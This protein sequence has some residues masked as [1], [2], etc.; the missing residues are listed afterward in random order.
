M[1]T[2]TNQRTSRQTAPSLQLNKSLVPIDQYAAR[3]GL[4]TSIVEECG[5]LGIVQLRTYKGKTFVVNAPISPCLCPS[6]ADK[7]PTRP[8]DKNTRAQKISELMQR[9]VSEKSISQ[10][11]PKIASPEEPAESKDETVTVGAIS[12]LVKKMFNNAPKITAK[13]VQT[14]DDKTSR[15]QDTKKPVAAPN[16]TTQTRPLP[17]VQPPDMEIFEL[18]DEPPAAVH[19]TQE[20]REPVQ[21]PQNNGLQ[22]G[23]L[24]AQGRSKRIWQTTAVLSLGFLFM[25]VVANISLFVNRRTQL[26]R[27]DEANTSIQSLFDG[28]AQSDQQVENLRNEM[29][30]SKA[31]AG[32]LQSE[33]YISKDEL[34]TARNELTQARQDMENLRNELGKSRAEAGRFQAKLGSYETEISRL[35]IELDKSRAELKTAQDNFA[36]ATQELRTIRQRNAEAADRLNK[37]IQR[38]M[39]QLNKLNNNS[40]N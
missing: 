16:K 30:N 35:Q 38:L 3:E 18:P 37:R 1:T 22:P 15:G 13:S 23:I 10:N 32:R 19:E 2:E 40:Q 34:K 39:A 12:Q 25:A 27:L 8:I 9:V 7:E 17:P 28:T 33:L 36:L 21:I 6:E 29:S 24:T 4:S 11:D 14:V 20:I 26:A 5:K 31:Q